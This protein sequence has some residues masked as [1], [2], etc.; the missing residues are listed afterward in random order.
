MASLVQIGR[1]FI[2]HKDFRAH[3]VDRAEGQ[4]S[5]SVRRTGKDTPP[6]QIPKME[7]LHRILYST[8][9]LLRRPSF[10]F[11]P[12][13]NSLSVS[14]LKNWD[15]GFWNTEPTFRASSYIGV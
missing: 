15:F 3:S 5:A 8:A 1:R 13:A 9:D 7:R 6:Q 10:V 2:Q 12:K 14:R 11:R 4:R